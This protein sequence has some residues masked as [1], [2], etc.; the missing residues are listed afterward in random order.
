MKLNPI[1]EVRSTLRLGGQDRTLVFNAN[2]MIA[3]EQAT[4]KFFLHTVS[5]L[6]NAAYP[7]GLEKPIAR[8]PYEILSKVSMSDLRALLW[9]AMHDYDADDNPVWP[10]KLTQVG[11]LLTLP[12]IIPAFSVFLRGQTANSPTNNEMGESQAADEQAIPTNGQPQTM[13]ENGGER[14][15][16]LP[17]G[18]FV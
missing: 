8:S 16:E 5:E 9:A 15:I 1:A 14:G 6:M 7:E 12:D 4:G 3:F 18:A 13:Q 10:L 17:E 11:R 2:T